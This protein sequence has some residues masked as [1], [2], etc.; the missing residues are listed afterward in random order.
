M[1][2][3]PDLWVALGLGLVGSGGAGVLVGAILTHRRED[4]RDRASAV[5]QHAEL[6]LKQIAAQDAHAASQ[7]EQ[8]ERLW[9]ARRADAV[10]IR[11]QGD[12][13]DVLEAH[14]WQGL[15]PPPPARPQGL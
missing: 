3:S 8:I 2:M 11:A 12:H 15:P 4:R 9:G 1:T 14:I 5:M 7:D 6:L 10:L 13:I